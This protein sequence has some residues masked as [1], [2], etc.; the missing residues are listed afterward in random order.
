MASSSNLLAAKHSSDGVSLGLP[1]RAPGRFTLFLGAA[2]GVGKTYEMLQ[3]AHGKKAEGV[4]VVIGAVETHG[5]EDIR[6]LTGVLEIIPM[7][8]LS[9]KG[10]DL[11]EM[12]FDAI[13]ARRPQLVLVDELAHVN[14]SGSVRP[15]RYLDI[16]E[17]LAVG[18]DVYSTVN[19][20]HFESL[21]GTIASIAKIR[22]R[23]TVPDSMIELADS[24]EFVDLPPE[25]LLDRLRDGKVDTRNLK[26][27]AL[28]H[29]FSPRTLSAIRDLALR[30]T[31]S[32][33]MLV[34]VTESPHSIELL[35]S[36]KRMATRLGAEWTALYVETA[37]FKRL[38]DSERES[39]S[40]ILLTA[41]KLGGEAVIIPGRHIADDV[42]RYARRINAKNIIVRKSERSRWSEVFHGS[43]VRELGK[44]AWNIDL[45]VV[46]NER[47]RREEPPKAFK[48]SFKRTMAAIWPYGFSAG[49]VGITI[50]LAFLITDLTTRDNLS[51]I[52]LLP[53]LWAAL[54]YGLW[55]SIAASV[56]S[57]LAW[58]F[59]FTQP[60]YSLEMDNP[61]D[62]LALF[63]FFVVALVISE[64]V[65]A[66]KQ[67]S[68]RLAERAEVRR[69]FYAVSQ[70]L[71]EAG[72][73]EE[74]QRIIAENV[75]AMFECEAIVLLPG[76]DGLHPRAASGPQSKLNAMDQAAAQW[77]L[78]RNL[79]MGRGTKSLPG[80]NYLFFPLPTRQGALGVIGIKREPAPLLLPEEQS[81]L[82][83]LLDQATVAI[84]R[85]QLAETIDQARLQVEIERLR[86]TMLISVSHDLRTPLTTIIAAHSTLQSIGPNGDPEI[87]TE[88]V[89]R[90]QDEAER[91][92]RFIG[93]LLDITRLESGNLNIRLEPIDLEDVVESA[94]DRAQSLLSDHVVDID[95]A[96]DIPMVSADFLL[97]EQIL[98][99]L[100]DNAA[101]YAPENTT[102]GIRTH[103]EQ[104]LVSIAVID[105]GEGIPPQSIEAIFNKF[106][107][108]QIGD[109]K[110]AGTGLGLPICRGFAEAMGGTV[111]ATNRQDRSGTIFSI[112]LAKASSRMSTSEG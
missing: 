33:R 68:E 100:L 102:I 46:T 104:E 76:A 55:P 10:H 7:R 53:V 39:L 99:N 111:I 63:F 84:E 71:A 108:L 88:L 89:E 96:P 58:D 1:Q 15:T 65:A 3:T 23:D 19:I 101:K 107:R 57:V 85:A 81:L 32:D 67:L 44:H 94:L 70:K 29:Y 110:G 74:L 49:I 31:A 47:V 97:L 90:A 105:E 69:R 9:H 28:A 20:Q 91:L 73:Q 50:G 26:Q 112:R 45:H 2:P 25:K 51:I 30:A 8:K 48:P 40:E 75:A 14:A 103:M 16:Q 4:D 54:R 38:A 109:R 37:R 92:N 17:L 80:A 77:A 34:C 86:N 12:D 62:I 27:Q 24:I 43:V 5:Q 82:S 61:R 18:I 21:N 52:F 72:S 93:N 95:L 59:F 64:L 35:Y 98:F 36:A 42:L 87:R 13:L 41:Q 83:T 106:A 60:L 11:E 78:S 66:K 79:P 56:L 22:V 6:A